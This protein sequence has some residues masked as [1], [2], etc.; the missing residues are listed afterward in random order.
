MKVSRFHILYAQKGVF[1]RRDLERKTVIDVE[2]AGEMRPKN[3]RF[4]FAHGIGRIIKG[5]V[6]DAE[7]YGNET[8]FINHGGKYSANV[9][10]KPN[11]SEKD[12]SIHCFVQTT[13]KILAGHELLLDYR[14]QCD[15]IPTISR[16]YTPLEVM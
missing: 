3:T 5:W 7:N 14:G 16:P 10:F 2:Y 4:A 11:Y 12:G 13:R 8:R 6:I 15:F 9:V 1:A